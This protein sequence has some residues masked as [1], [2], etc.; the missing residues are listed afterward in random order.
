MQQAIQD[1]LGLKPVEQDV[2]VLYE[3]EK[4]QYEDNFWKV[5][6]Y[7]IYCWKEISQNRIE[8]KYFFTLFVNIKYFIY[9]SL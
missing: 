9:F 1:S 4:E 7:T 2:I 3:G 8:A 6:I 5:L